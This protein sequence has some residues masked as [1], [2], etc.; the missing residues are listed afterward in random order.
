MPN[1]VAMGI[2]EKQAEEVLRDREEQYRLI[3]EQSHH[4]IYIQSGNKVVYANDNLYTLL[5]VSPKMIDKINIL[6]YIHSADKMIIEKYIDQQNCGHSDP[7]TIEVQIIDGKDQLKMIELHLTKII[8]KGRSAFIG[9]ARDITERKIEE[10]LQKARYLISQTIH[11]SSDIEAMYRSLQQIIGKFIRTENFFIATYDEISDTVHFPYY[12]DEEDTNAILFEHEKWFT[13]YV[14][15]SRQPL[16][17][18][19]DNHIQLIQNSKL[20]KDGNFVMNWLGVPLKIP[21]NKSFGAL[22]VK[23]YQENLSYSEKDKE[24][25]TFLSSQVAMVIK[26]K[27]DEMHLQYLSFRDSLSG[28]YN[29]R[30]FEEEMRRMDRRREGS[31]GLIILDVDGLKLVNDIFGHDCGDVQLINVATLLKGCFRE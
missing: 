16:C 1:Q 25:L 7:S 29:R 27:Q 9:V 21:S 14:I 24:V 28:L 13:N 3:V 10:K 31:V 20:K 5:G 18:S 2:V 19:Q 17:V 12:V 22:G 6:N 11:S 8:Y 30:Y 26:H 23:T 15:K 4:A